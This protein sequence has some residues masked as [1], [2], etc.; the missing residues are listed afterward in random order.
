MYG[1]RTSCVVISL[2]GKRAED[3]VVFFSDGVVECR[4]SAFKLT[5]TMRLIFS[6]PGGFWNDGRG[7]FCVSVFL[8][9]CLDRMF[10]AQRSE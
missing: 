6:G 4:Q 10:F 2:I 5:I 3:E 9:K 7:Q 1:I 8:K